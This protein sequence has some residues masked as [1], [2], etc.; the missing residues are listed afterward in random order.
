M[1][2]IIVYTIHDMGAKLSSQNVAKIN[3]VTELYFDD[4]ENVTYQ[5]LIDGRS[6]SLGMAYGYPRHKNGVLFWV[7]PSIPIGLVVDP[8]SK[9]IKEYTESEYKEFEKTLDPYPDLEI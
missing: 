3:A 9:A 1:I 4:L 6:Q 7:L 2:D 5:M 8:T